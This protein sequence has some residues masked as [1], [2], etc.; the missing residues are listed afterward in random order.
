MIACGPAVGTEGTTESG[1]GGQS[2]LSGETS[3]LQTSSDAESGA[4]TS[5]SSASGGPQPMC[6]DGVAEGDE[7]CDDGNEEN[8]D[9]CSAMC[10]TSGTTRWNQLLPQGFAVGLSAREG[11]VAAAVQQFVNEFEPTIV[12]AGRD[13]IGA[14]LGEF[15]DVGGLSDRDV[16]RAPVAMLPDGRVALG[17]PA[18]AP[19]NGSTTRHF[20]I[21]DFDRGIVAS[22]VDEDESRGQYF[23]TTF[24]PSGIMVLRNLRFGEEQELVLQQFDES[25]ALLDTFPLG[26]SATEHRP[27]ER[28][29]VPERLLPLRLVFTTAPAGEIVLHTSFSSAPWYSTPI[30]SQTPGEVV[31][32]FSDASGLRLWTG[33]ELVTFD[34]QDHPSQRQALSF[35]GELLWADADGLVVGLDD[36]VVLYDAAGQE[37]LSVAIPPAED[38]EVLRPQYVRPD[39]EQGCLFVFADAGVPVD[40]GTAPPTSLLHIVR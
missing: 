8:A 7:A 6:G 37:R 11:R 16:A 15:I 5:G 27:P 26:L 30:A 14:S 3:G 12:I 4:L 23:G 32:S 39:P 17:Y 35:E 34:E 33:T 20:G 2:T 19:R 25:A 18:T 13:S 22:Y 24:N 1:T 21:L 9:G 36:S 38:G 29:A 40:F 28:G 10:E 31:S